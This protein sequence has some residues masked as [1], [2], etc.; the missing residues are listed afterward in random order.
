MK[1]K[2]PYVWFSAYACIRRRTKGPL[3]KTGVALQIPRE[4]ERSRHTCLDRRVSEGT[5]ALQSISE[6]Y[7]ERSEMRPSFWLRRAFQNLICY[8]IVAFRSL[9]HPIKSK[10]YMN[11]LSLQDIQLI[12]GE[13]FNVLILRLPF[14]GFRC[15]SGIR[16]LFPRQTGRRSGSHVISARAHDIT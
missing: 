4:G 6:D 1:R 16:S 12:S 5:Y 7:A 8:T 3:D 15:R 9:S 11:C 14:M 13:S 10:V 2:Q